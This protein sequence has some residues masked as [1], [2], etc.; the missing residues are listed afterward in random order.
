MGRSGLEPVA[1]ALAAQ[2]GEDRSPASFS[3]LRRALLLTLQERSFGR[4]GGEILFLPPSLLTRLEDVTVLWKPVLELRLCLLS[5]PRS[6]LGRARS[7]H[8]RLCLPW[9]LTPG[10][11]QVGGICPLIFFSVNPALYECY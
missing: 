8:G 9:L 3:A 2:C 7:G 11:R 6:S 5:I 4:T 1:Q 10:G